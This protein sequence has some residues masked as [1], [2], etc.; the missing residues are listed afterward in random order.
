MTL[1]KGNGS[2]PETVRFIGLHLCYSFRHRRGKGA[3]ELHFLDFLSGFAYNKP[4][5]IWI[6]IAI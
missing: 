4:E 1:G 5:L 3:A 2:V 6:T